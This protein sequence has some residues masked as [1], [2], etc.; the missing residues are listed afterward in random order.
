MALCFFAANFLRA[1]FT[2]RVRMAFFVDALCLAGIGFIPLV[3]ESIWM[4]SAP[5]NAYLRG[6]QVARQWGQP[7]LSAKVGI[8]KL[9]PPSHRIVWKADLLRSMLT[10]SCVSS[11]CSAHVFR[12]SLV[13]F[14][15]H[16][17]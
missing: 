6:T 13:P 5:Y 9:S 12:F 2:F 15:V 1:D 3:A 16:A 7:Q 10:L 8:N 11:S 14:Q 17:T 4:A